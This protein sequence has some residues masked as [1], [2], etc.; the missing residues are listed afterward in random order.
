MTLPKLK[1]LCVALR[2]FI[3]SQKFQTVDPVL[4]ETAKSDLL[5]YEK[6]VKIAESKVLA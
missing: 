4:Q 5:H 3:K 2:N 1:A 6:K